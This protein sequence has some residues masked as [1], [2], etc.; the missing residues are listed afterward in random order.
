MDPFHE[1]EKLAQERAGQQALARRNGRMIAETV[2][3]GAIRFVASVRLAAVATAGG[4]SLRASVVQGE[5]GF[6]SASERAV[7]IDLARTAAD[8][9]GA[10]GAG[11]EGDVGLLA[12]DL[13][14]R[15]RYRV[16]GRLV[17]AEGPGKLLLRV[18]EAFPN[19]PQYIRGRQVLPASPRTERREP[20]RGASLGPEQVALVRRA[21]TGF[22]ASRHP[23]RGLD[24]SHRGGH[25][26]FVEVV[27]P[28]RLRVPDY[29]GNGLFNTLGNLLVDSRAGLALLDF[30]AG[31]VLEVSGR[32]SVR[33]GPERSWELAIERFLERD[34][35][36]ALRW[37]EPEAD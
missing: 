33:W 16:N 12:I 7:E 37:S 21:D 10:L 32:A 25:P 35:P 15:A 4:D 14:T 3:R 1:G 27:A 9:D 34:L 36:L 6:L 24:A 30:E 8:P 23:E 29:A 19:C 18:R 26:G 2:P 13:G 20:V 11:L 5:P 31:R 28:D 17:A 22:V